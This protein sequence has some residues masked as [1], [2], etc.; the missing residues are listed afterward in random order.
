MARADYSLQKYAYM[1][2]ESMNGTTYTIDLWDSSSSG[3]N[4][5]TLA[6]DGVDIS[7]QS[8]SAED[9][10]SPIITSNCKLKILVTDATQQAFIDGIRT[11]RQERETWIT[12]RRG[13][14]GAFL[15]SGYIIM[16]LETREDASYPYVQTLT[17]VDGLASLKDIPFLRETNSTSGA[18]PSFPYV[19]SDTWDNAGYQRIIG[20]SSAWIKI[21]LD[22]TGQLLA[23]DDQVGGTL[24]NYTIQTAFN[25]WNEDMGPVPGMGNDP[26]SNMKLNMS[27]LY[28]ED[29][30][31]YMDVPMAYDVLEALCRNLNMRVVFWEQCFHFIQLD[32]YN[33]NENTTYTGS[34]TP[35]N[36]PTRVYYHSGSSQTDRNYLGSTQYSLYKQVFENDTSPGTGLQKLAGSQYQ[37]L[38]PIK[39]VMGTYAERA[40]EN[41]YSGFPEPPVTLANWP[42][43]S[44]TQDIGYVTIMED[45]LGQEKIMQ[46][47]DA[48]DLAGF[49]CKIYMD[50]SNTA[51]GWLD[52]ETCWSIRAKPSSE[53]S[54]TTG[55]NKLLSVDSN[56]DLEWVAVTGHTEANMIQNGGS[57]A[58]NTSFGDIAAPTNAHDDLYIVNTVR[59]YPN[60][61]PQHDTATFFD[62]ATDLTTQASDNMIPTHADFDGEWDFQF[63]TYVAIGTGDAKYMGTNR[64]FYTF[65]RITGRQ[66]YNSGNATTTFDGSPIPSGPKSPAVYQFSYSNATDPNFLTPYFGQFTPVKSDGTFGIAQ[67]S[68][69]VSQA[70]NDSYLYDIGE[71]VWGDGSGSNSK[72][73]I[74]VYDG[75]DWVF[76]N[77]AGKWAKGVYTWGGSSFSYAT[78]T[79]DKKLTVL[80]AE[81][82]LYN[83]SRPLLTLSTTSALS[84]TDKTFPSSTRLKFMNPIARLEDTDGKKYIMKRMSWN[85]AKDEVRLDMYQMSYNVPST[86]VVGERDTHST[87]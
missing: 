67:S 72:S 56:G 22:Y 78:P 77:A 75:S 57:P 42:P 38:P 61:S 19:R 49:V 25:W 23:D 4:E 21:L 52:M 18:V 54:W 51:T 16:D 3:S 43:T 50:Y 71:T 30:N 69:Q 62:S 79:Y 45:G 24:E 65:G 26:L 34:F 14:S 86:V 73:T 87:G 44:P 47:T 32:E 39:K 83:Q 37:A 6:P 31:G 85:G 7:Y 80:L 2:L 84:E 48:K 63:F 46:V 28:S 74:K 59:L 20:N 58:T 36:I 29:S 82:I 35:S 12:V 11:S 60:G 17:A 70:G 1:S 55:T 27:P 66:Y 53:T 40:G 81:Q 15:W 5:W 76:V 13:S 9:K 33:S 68:V 41:L 10:Y 64:P 8:E